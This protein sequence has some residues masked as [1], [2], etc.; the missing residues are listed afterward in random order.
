[1]YR[2]VFAFRAVWHYT[3]SGFRRCVLRVSVRSCWS[4]FPLEDR[5]TVVWS[6]VAIFF[7]EDFLCFVTMR[8]HICI[9]M[10]MNECG[11]NELNAV[12]TSISFT[13]LSFLRGDPSVYGQMYAVYHPIN[14]SSNVSG[15]QMAYTCRFH[16]GIAYSKLHAQPSCRHI[17][18]LC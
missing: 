1:M 13:P 11:H 10:M 4:D 16:C 2:L 7:C 8:R 9:R 12:H 3:P 6:P 14:R 18:H 15:C 5:L 17:R